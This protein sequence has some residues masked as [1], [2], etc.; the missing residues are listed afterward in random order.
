MRLIFKYYYLKAGAKEIFKVLKSTF[1]TL[2]QIY[3]SYKFK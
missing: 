3:F 1:L 2:M